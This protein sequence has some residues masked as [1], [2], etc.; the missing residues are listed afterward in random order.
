MNQETPYFQTQFAQYRVQIRNAEARFDGRVLFTDLTADVSSGELLWIVGENGIGKTTLLKMLAGLIRLP[1]K[2]IGW[3]DGSGAIRPESSLSYQ[4]HNG[5]TKAGLTLAEDFE[6]WGRMVTG[7]CPPLSALSYVGLATALSTKT[8]H[9]S[10][11][12]KRRLSLARLLV[13][14][15][16][17]WVMDEPM[18]GLDADGRSLVTD[19]VRQH[20]ARG[21]MAVIASHNPADIAA[22]RVMRLTLGRQ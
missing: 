8:Q 17:I 3:Y 9:L 2:C 4:T 19:I 14:N 6:F 5:Y 15:R 21:G 18:A 16:P 12:Q 20:L 10:A 13:A 11:G 7:S 22:E 1:P